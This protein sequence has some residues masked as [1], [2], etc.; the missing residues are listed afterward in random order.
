MTTML[1]IRIGRE[2]LALDALASADPG[3]VA[4]IMR[5]SFEALLQPDG[6]K[7]SRSTIV[8]RDDPVAVWA[9]CGRVVKEPRPPAEI[10]HYLLVGNSGA[11]R[12]RQG[13]NFD[14]PK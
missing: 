14:I 3:R 9:T 12:A 10:A 8:L 6:P 2:L 11:C 7:Q 4:E 13:K 5:P 1:G